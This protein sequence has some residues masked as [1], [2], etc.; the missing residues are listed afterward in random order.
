MLQIHNKLQAKRLAK[1]EGKVAEEVTR[2]KVT[3]DEPRQALQPVK[4]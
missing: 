1:A 2:P 3:H 4:R